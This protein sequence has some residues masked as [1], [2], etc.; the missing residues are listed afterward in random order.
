VT[1]GRAQGGLGTRA[2]SGAGLLAG[3]IALICTAGCSA[4][5]GPGVSDPLAGVGSLRQDEVSLTLTG[6][7]VQVQVTP[8]ARSVLE[9]TAPDTRRRLS[10]LVPAGAEGTHFLLSVFTEAPGG[11]AFEP[12]DVILENRGRT[13]RPLRIRGMTPGWGSGQLRQQRTEQAV[14]TFSNELDLELPLVVIVAGVRNSAWE[15][16]RPRID[17]ERARINARG[18]SQP[19]RSNF[20]I[21]R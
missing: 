13:F 2:R 20:L 18:V 15:S 8:L 17:A 19:S 12:A 11:R 6:D 21:F 9:V 7:D 1:R 14:Y 5:P 3:F 16:I 4:A 10:S